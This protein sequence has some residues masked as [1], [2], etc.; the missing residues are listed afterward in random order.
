MENKPQN[1]NKKITR[2]F[3][4]YEFPVPGLELQLGLLL[5]GWMLFLL[6]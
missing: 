1:T 3:K 2:N 6:S 4:N 5:H